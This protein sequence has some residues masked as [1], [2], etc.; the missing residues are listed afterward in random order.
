MKKLLV[1]GAAAALMMAAGP[2][3]AHVAPPPGVAQGTTPAPLQPDMPGMKMH[4][5]GMGMGGFGARLFGMA[6]ANHD[7]RVSLQEAETAALAHF[8]RADL[9]H[10]GK[11]TPDERGRA[12]TFILQRR[13]G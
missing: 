9:N 1:G 4:M 8:D 2:A 11:L 13:P 5:H 3:F 6:D 12:H 10:D 7:G